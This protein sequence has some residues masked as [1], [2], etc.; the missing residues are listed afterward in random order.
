MRYLNFVPYMST[1]PK[2]P[3]KRS[4][5][6]QVYGI[7]GITAV[8]LLLGI[9]GMVVLN[10]H[11]IAQYFRENIEITI[12][13]KDEVKDADI[14]KLQQDIESAPYSKRVEFVSKSMAADR[15]KESFDE[16]FEDV[17]GYNPLFASFDLRLFSSYAQQDSIEPIKQNLERYSAVKEVYYQKNLV[18][19]INK[20]VRNVSIAIIVFSL[21][22]FFIAITLI[23]NTIRLMMYSQRFII[24]SMQLV[25]AT[26]KFIT[27][28]FITQSI[29]N[30][31]ISAFVAIAI[32]ALI[33]IYIQNSF[34]ELT[35]LRDIIRFV[36]VAVLIFAVGIFISWWSTKRSVKKYL[37]MKLDD[38]Y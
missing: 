34:P 22:F 20:N 32:L 18:Q 1:D 35:V 31:L 11:A 26:R 29:N 9:L 25:G 21:L 4:K 2:K 38:L 10:A 7:V 16:Q 23:D 36:I 3:V 28:P 24:R 30:G 37:K 6:S 19:L 17:L 33:T 15:F 27:R 8:L 5:P 14:I 12:I 13:L